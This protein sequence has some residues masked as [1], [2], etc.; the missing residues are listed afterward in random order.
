MTA[1]SCLLLAIAAFAALAFMG[2]ANNAHAQVPGNIQNVMD[3]SG[4]STNPGEDNK[5]GKCTG[6]FVNPIT[7][8]CWSC[9]FPM[10]VGG[11][12]VYPGNRP[13]PKNPTLP[14][15]FCST[16]FPRIGIAMGFWEPVRLVDVTTKP[17][18]FTNLGGTKISPGF[19]IGHGRAE[20]TNEG[21]NTGAKW[22]VHWY[23][24]P[25]IYWMEVLADVACLEQSSFDIAY[26]SE[27]DP[28]WQD[29]ALTALINPEVAL[30]ANPI[31]QVA[32]TA[33][34]VAAT[35]KLPFDEL[36]WCAGCQGR[37]YPMDGNVGEEVG[38]IQSSRLA[39]TRMAFKLHRQGLAWGTSGSKALCAKYP[40]P[41]MRKQQYRLQAVN[42]YPMVKGRYACPTLGSS[43]MMPGSGRAVPAVG[44]DFGYLVWRKRNCCVL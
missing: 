12:K 4:S 1:R 21:P 26:V 20:R 10:S 44:E 8:I 22:N 18:C 36:F 40:M 37:M 24:Y 7:D 28:L 19:D 30:F 9:L 35:A 33:D 14:L 2:S 6:N 42:P 15:C 25:L 27:L 11:L 41:I 17:W 32:C 34:C 38:Q 3:K 16:P 13:D 39:A 23:V 31:A 43:D 29:D 5:P